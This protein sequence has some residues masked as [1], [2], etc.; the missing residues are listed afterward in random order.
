M[1]LQKLLYNTL[2]LWRVLMT[3][4]DENYC[5]ILIKNMNQS[6][7]SRSCWIW[8]VKLPSVTVSEKKTKTK[9]SVP[10][11]LSMHVKCI[12]WSLSMTSIKAQLQHK[13][14][15]VLL[16][17]QTFIFAWNLQN[18]WSCFPDVCPGLHSLMRTAAI[19][20]VYLPH[21]AHI[22][23]YIL[24]S[25]LFWK[26]RGPRGRSVTNNISGLDAKSSQNYISWCH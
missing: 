24:D 13:T 14:A 12:L 3:N 1:E 20:F 25:R 16:L 2:R 23:V 17:W 26:S 19:S 11:Q 18:S 6:Q 9:N 7:P 8:T 4:K 5:F 22:S 15:L 10:F 21:S